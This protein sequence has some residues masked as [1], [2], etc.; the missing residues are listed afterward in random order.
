M[1]IVKLTLSCLALMASLLIL[2]SFDSPSSGT[3]NGAAQASSLKIGV[4]NFKRCVETSKLGK[5]EQANFEALKKQMES[6]LGE[7]EKNS[8]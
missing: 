2:S 6:V 8:Q 5:L 7:K 4:V 1:K 3:A